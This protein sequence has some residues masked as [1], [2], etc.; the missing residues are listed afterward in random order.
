MSQLDW[1]HNTRYL[2]DDLDLELKAVYENSF[3]GFCVFIAPMEPEYDAS[4]L[5]LFAF[6]NASTHELWRFFPQK[7]KQF[8][9]AIGKMESAVC[10]GVDQFSGIK[11]ASYSPAGSLPIN[12]LCK[13]LNRSVLKYAQLRLKHILPVGEYLDMMTP[14]RQVSL[15]TAVRKMFGDTSR[16]ATGL[17]YEDILDQKWRHGLVQAVEKMENELS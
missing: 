16:K 15:L 5:Q 12:Q 3:P 17:P 8:R 14:E 7:R 6:P 2:T 4:V 9:Y 10:G 11:P 1:M 13:Q